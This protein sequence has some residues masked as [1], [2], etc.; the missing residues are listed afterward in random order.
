MKNWFDG[1]CL[2]KFHTSGILANLFTN[3]NEIKYLHYVFDIMLQSRGIIKIPDLKSNFFSKK[4][5]YKQYQ[6]HSN[7]H[8]KNHA[9]TFSTNIHYSFFFNTWND[10]NLRNIR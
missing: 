8:I 1:L 10:I 5:M 2:A 9:S 6:L 7:Y 3:K 4:R